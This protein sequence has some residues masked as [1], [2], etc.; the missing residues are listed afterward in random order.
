M[1]IIL[2]LHVTISHQLFFIRAET[3]DGSFIWIDPLNQ[4]GL[5]KTVHNIQ[6]SDR[7]NKSSM[8][9]EFRWPET[10]LKDLLSH[11]N[12]LSA[13]KLLLYSV[14]VSIV[15]M[16]ESLF[17]SHNSK[18]DERDYQEEKTLLWIQKKCIEEIKQSVSLSWLKSIQQTLK[19]VKYNGFFICIWWFPGTKTGEILI[20]MFTLAF[21]QCSWHQIWFV[22]KY[23]VQIFEL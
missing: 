5:N 13:Y 22:N 20:F 4:W 8:P 9:I 3:H 15:C 1:Y 14:W 17:W 10:Y 7:R 16:K 23:L 6:V 19:I 11:P 18:H 21:I 12:Q 2:D